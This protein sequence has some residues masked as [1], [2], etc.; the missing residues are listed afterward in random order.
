MPLQAKITEFLVVLSVIA[1]VL[2]R[3]I[4]FIVAHAF[5]TG[6]GFLGPN[7]NSRRLATFLLATLFGILVVSQTSLGLL[8][9]VDPKASRW[10]DVVFTGLLLAAGT[11]PIHSLLRLLELKK[12]TQDTAVKARS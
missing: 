10:F 3:I 5:P 1:L 4:E 6:E 2:E 7:T 8:Q 12:E 11:Q 9:R